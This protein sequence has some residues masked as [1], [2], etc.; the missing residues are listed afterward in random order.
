VMAAS[1]SR[2]KRRWRNPSAPESPASRRAVAAAQLTD[3]R[4]AF[5]VAAS[6]VVRTRL[7][8]YP[9]RE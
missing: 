3:R 4:P 1:S 7:V 8:T 6:I 5:P 2:G 9:S